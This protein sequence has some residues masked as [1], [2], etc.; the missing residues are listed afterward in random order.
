[1]DKVHLCHDVQISNNCVVGIGTTIAGECMLDD[2]AILSGNV[3][4]H[5]YCHIGSWTLVQSGCRISKDVPPYVIMSGNPVAYHGVKRCGSL[6]TSQYIGKSPPSHR[7]RIP[8][9]LSG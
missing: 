8:F 2:C 6:A 3:T 4:L 5:Q 1:M 7:Q 9:D